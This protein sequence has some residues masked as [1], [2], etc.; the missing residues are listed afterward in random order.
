MTFCDPYHT[1]PEAARLLR[2][3]G[4]FAFMTATPISALCQDMQTGQIGQTLL[5]DYFSLHRIEWNS[6][7]DFQLPYG[8]WI[9]L[10]RHTGFI[11]EDLIETQPAIGATSAY[12]NAAE[13]A[14]A[15]RFPMEHL[16]K[17]RKEG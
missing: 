14:W 6:E 5:N 10:F 2:T 4:L 7:V 13:T 15:R 8:E 1:V 11:V 3:G 17:L 12:L 16:W 9:R